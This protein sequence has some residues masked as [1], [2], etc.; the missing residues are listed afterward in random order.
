MIKKNIAE[1]IITIEC[2]DPQNTD[3]QALLR[4][5]QSFHQK[6]KVRDG[7]EWKVVPPQIILYGEYVNRSVFLY[8]K[9]NIYPSPISL[10]DLEKHN[11]FIRCSKSM[12][13][14]IHEITKLKSEVSGSIRATLSNEECILI[15]RHY[16][17]MLR[18]ALFNRV[19]K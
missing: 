6:L 7:D 4:Y 12:V 8:T 19:Q 14:N 11:S 18:K 5:I 15:S 1:D 2:K 3:I 13:V 16:A 17:S 10:S 9:E